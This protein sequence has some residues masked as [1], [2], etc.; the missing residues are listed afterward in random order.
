MMDSEKRFTHNGIMGQ[1]SVNVLKK[2][3]GEG[4]AVTQDLITIDAEKAFK[5]NLNRSMGS[6]ISDSQTSLATMSSGA[7]SADTVN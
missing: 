2:I 1:Y 4:G 7:S 3:E 6:I 5:F